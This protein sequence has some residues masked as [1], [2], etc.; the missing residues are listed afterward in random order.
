[1]L[2]F[3]ALSALA[4]LLQYLFF[5][6]GL[7]Q[8]AAGLPSDGELLLEQADRMLLTLLIGSF[9]VLL[10]VTLLIGIL[11]THRLLAPLERLQ[12][13]LAE[14]ARGERPEDLRLRRTDDLQELCRL[15]NAV[16]APMRSRHEADVRP[17]TRE[18]I[19]TREAA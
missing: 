16:T 19:E 18:G 7:Q 15:V 6:R 13:F 1:M 14:V 8:L 3:G 17:L 11:A 2:S 12:R 5:D 10:P 9:V 4:L